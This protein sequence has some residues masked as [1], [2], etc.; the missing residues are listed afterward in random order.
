MDDRFTK[1][2]RQTA[3][4]LSSQED[5]ANR[6]PPRRDASF[7]PLGD[8]PHGGDVLTP[9]ML[10][11]SAQSQRES[12][13]E[14]LDRPPSSDVILMASHF[15]VESVLRWPIFTQIFPE[16][17]GLIASSPMELIGNSKHVN[18]RI[19]D[20]SKSV[21]A[22]LLG[23]EPKSLGALVQNFIKSNYGKSPIFDI[24]ALCLEARRVEEN[25][26]S[27]DAGSC[28]IVSIFQ[29]NASRVTLFRLSNL[30]IRNSF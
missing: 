14:T 23:C 3:L 19:A 6:L 28:L 15:T 21:Q 8:A 7:S 22:T 2:Q 17:E 20:V 24:D 27:W 16:L 10:E 13:P 30:P 29:F 9:P 25:G 18:P 1:L 12:V 5:R 26:I 4:N 11:N